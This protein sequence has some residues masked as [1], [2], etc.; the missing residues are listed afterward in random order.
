MIEASVALHVD[1]AVHLALLGFLDVFLQQ[2]VAFHFGL[3]ELFAV[4]AEL[5]Y[6]I[7]IG[8]QNALLMVDDY[9]SVLNVFND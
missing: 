6:C 1:S 5:Y 7:L 3:E 8:V 2:L 4:F 9:N